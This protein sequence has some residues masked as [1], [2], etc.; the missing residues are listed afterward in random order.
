MGA[1]VGPDYVEARVYA[2]DGQAMERRV[3]ESERGEVVCVRKL[4]RAK[5]RPWL[6]GLRVNKKESH[7]PGV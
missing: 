7:V 1:F 6:A 2:W 5:E 3:A 4:R